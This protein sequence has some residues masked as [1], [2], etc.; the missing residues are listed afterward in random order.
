MAD[1]RHGWSGLAVFC[2][3]WASAGPLCC[4]TDQSGGAAGA[5]PDGGTGGAGTAVGGVG[6]GCGV[7]AAAAGWAAGGASA[8]TGTGG[9]PATDTGPLIWVPQDEQKRASVPLRAP[10]RAQAV[11]PGSFSSTISR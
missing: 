9:A 8:A 1:L 2:S 10:Q 4:G 11:M 3:V 6:A 5:G 7:G